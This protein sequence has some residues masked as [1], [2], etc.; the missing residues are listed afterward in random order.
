MKKLIVALS[1]LIIPACSGTDWSKINNYYHL[2]GVNTCETKSYYLAGSYPKTV[3]NKG[4][5]KARTITISEFVCAREGRTP[6]GAKVQSYEYFSQ[7]HKSDQQNIYVLFVPRG[8][9][10][11]SKYLYR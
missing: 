11:G 7:L 5:G 2:E 8:Y 1:V 10:Q 9:E 6:A 4:S 3:E